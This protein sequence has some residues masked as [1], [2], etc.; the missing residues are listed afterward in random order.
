MNYTSGIYYNA[1]TILF[2]YNEQTQNCCSLNFSQGKIPPYWTASQYVGSQVCAN[3]T[4]SNCWEGDIMAICFSNTNV[5]SCLYNLTDPNVSVWE[6]IVNNF[7]SGAPDQ[8]QFDL[9]PWLTSSC[10]DGCSFI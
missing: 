6:F 4:Y 5:P 8:S 1:F 10:S 7:T 2:A 9:P 3:H